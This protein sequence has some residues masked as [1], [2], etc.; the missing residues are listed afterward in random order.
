[1]ESLRGRDG[2]RLAS[3]TSTRADGE[4]LL[5]VQSLG[6]ARVL[7]GEH[8]L[9][10]T[11][12]MLLSLLLRVVYSPGGAVDR[13]VLLDEL[14]PGQTLL[15]Q[16]GNLRQ[17]LY[18]LRSMGVRVALA[19]GAV[20]FDQRQLADTFAV[21]R[22]ADRFERDVIK[23]TEPFG[24]FLPGYVAPSDAWQRW[25]EDVR[26]VVHGD[27]RRVLVDQLRTRRERADWGGA[28]VLS[29]WLL[30][31]DPLNEDA[32]LTM[33]E[34]RMVEGA[35]AEAVGI[36][37]R[38]L[39]ELGPGAGDIRLPA[40]QLRRRFVEP[41]ARR[42]PSL[43]STER[44]FMGRE[45]EMAAL[46]LS[47]R[48]ARWH[49][50]SAVLLHGPPGIGKTRL[51][52]ELSKVAQIEG[53]REVSIE[54]RETDQARP[55]AVLQDALPLLLASPGA[56]GSAPESLAVIR[57]LVGD[58]VPE[59][60]V[61][62]AYEPTVADEAS[63]A[64]S[65]AERYER[66]MRTIRRQSIRHAIIDLVAAVS[67]EQPVFLVIDDVHWLDDASWEVMSDLIQRVGSMR[68]FILLTS[69]FGT[70][71]AERPA[72][73]PAKLVITNLPGL[74][75][76]DCQ[77]LARAIGED[78]A[79]VLTEDIEHWII[80]NSEG[81]PLM[82]RALVDH[83][84]ITGD[85]SDVPPTLANLLEQRLDRL[86]STA[87]R[88]LQTV[89]LLGRSAAL[90]RLEA[91][92]GL[93]THELLLAIEQLESEGCLSIAE[94]SC[95]AT[96][97][98]VGRIARGR[99]SPLVESALRRTISEA[100]EVE[101]LAQGDQSLLLAA[102]QHLELSGR[103]DEVRRFALRHD[104]SLVR[105]GQPTSVLN[106]MAKL[107]S[108]DELTGVDR[109]LARLRVRL[110]SGNGSF[111]R[112]LAIMPGGASLL[113]DA[114]TLD[115]DTI[116]ECLSFVEAA[117][118]SDPI[119]DPDQ[120]AAFAARIVEREELDLAIRLRAADIGLVISSN[121][122]DSAIAET[123]YHGLKLSEDE[124]IRG[125][126]SQRVG[127]LYHTVFGDVQ[128]ANAL[129]DIMFG[130]ANSAIA[131]TSAITDSGRAGF[132]YRMIGQNESAHRALILARSMAYE[133][134]SPRLAEYPVWQ[135]AQLSID[136]GN[137]STAVDWTTELCELAAYDKFDPANSFL[138]GHLCQF[139]IFRG[140][141]AEAHNHL[142]ACRS[143]LSKMP[144]LR[145]TSYAMALELGIGLL[146]PD[147]NPPQALVE[148]ALERFERIAA[149]A[150][151]DLLAASVGGAL[152]RLNEQRSAFELV[153]D[154]LHNKRRERSQPSALLSALITRLRVDI[155]SD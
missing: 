34:C 35:K 25:L 123:C 28:E 117:Y 80:S 102:L 4:L 76:E 87:L 92:L 118:R 104:A 114:T 6:A 65:A 116:D 155:C 95:I 51:C 26:D 44:H 69:R 20:R 5:T 54:C 42:R 151:S 8:T 3:D 29:R 22:T 134:N 136:L 153:S 60:E 7:V 72:R 81:T 142:D 59:S 50:G 107:P 40:T 16:R 10:S 127:L 110:E 146:D 89:T 94:A 53:Y 18:K 128:T 68:L 143:S 48:R 86:T 56:L 71:R 9:G 63:A 150:G 12:G 129:A 78:L 121:T 79:A 148:A 132:V 98:L 152:L 124:I 24:E 19:A 17:A 73:M 139:A 1:M 30:Q 101:Y 85:A 130:R 154:Y 57:K 74:A 145:S 66:T 43:G 13:D 45:R 41:S 119:A 125:K 58:E 36:L 33:A 84:V 120:L 75:K 31:F 138:H 62:P 32:T 88:A 52:T 61:E 23:G 109:S 47:M 126:E 90:H 96:H 106:A 39:A 111:A 141:K 137:A 83:W 105:S 21:E 99:M 38:Y 108:L 55:L 77:R 49:D 140:L 97:D 131:S 149:R 147:W 37:D 93:P 14:W 144:H 115:T 64:I 11:S 46:T 82:L 103:P 70:V 135:L 67:D 91:A 27:V 112:A 100:L 133:I 122:C 15:R 2:A 113:Q